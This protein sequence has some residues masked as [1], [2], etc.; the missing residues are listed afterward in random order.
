VRPTPPSPPNLQ[1][2]R[3]LMVK[4]SGWQLF[5]RQFQP[6]LR[7]IMAAPLWCGLGCRSRTDG[8][9]HRSRFFGSTFNFDCKDD[10]REFHVLA[11]FRRAVYL[12]GRFDVPLTSTAH[13]RSVKKSNLPAI[14]WATVNT[15]SGYSAFG[16]SWH[17]YRIWIHLFASCQYFL[18]NFYNSLHRVDGFNNNT[19]RNRGTCRRTI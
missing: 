5:D 8:R 3:G 13:A 18:V 12:K 19:H 9:I 14:V 2:F 1:R 7:A 6:C 11:G 4:A 17:T 10:C 15:F 16:N